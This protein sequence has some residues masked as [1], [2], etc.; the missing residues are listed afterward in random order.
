MKQD[1][2]IR[3]EKNKS[4][5]A[6]SFTD[7]IKVVSADNLVENLI[8][9]SNRGSLGVYCMPPKF[10][11]NG[12]D[13]YKH[14]ETVAHLSEVSSLQASCCGRYVFSAGTDGIIFVYDVIEHMPAQTRR[15]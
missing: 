3:D 8:I 14:S 10:L 12:S 11:R 5:E 2:E 4:D 7:I 15:G 13:N 9:G 1:I 6:L